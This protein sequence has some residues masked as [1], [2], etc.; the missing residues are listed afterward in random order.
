MYRLTAQLM[1]MPE[2]RQTYQ[3][4]PGSSR[5][6]AT[7]LPELSSLQSEP[8]SGGGHPHGASRPHAAPLLC[9]QRY[10][11]P[12]FCSFPQ[13]KMMMTCLDASQQTECL[14]QRAV[15]LYIMFKILHQHLREQP[16]ALPKRVGLPQTRSCS[17]QLQRPLNKQCGN[18]QRCC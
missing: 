10:P 7:L 1:L 11:S 15:Q 18:S 14:M 12:S 4:Q 17:L 2:C 6:D 5:S 9:P 3:K 13:L 8:D 16:I